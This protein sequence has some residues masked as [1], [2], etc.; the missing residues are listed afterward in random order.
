MVRTDQEQGKIER[1]HYSV[2]DGNA[3]Y[4]GDMKLRRVILML[5]SLYKE[6]EM[7]PLS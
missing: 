5:I 1:H 4:K 6:W 3:L 7:D 2:L